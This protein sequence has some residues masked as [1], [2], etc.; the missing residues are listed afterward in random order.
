[1]KSFDAAIYIPGVI[2]FKN[3]ICVTLNFCVIVRFSKVTLI[4]VQII[5]NLRFYTR[6]EN[7]INNTAEALFLTGI[8][9]YFCTSWF[10]YDR[11]FKI[12]NYTFYLNLIMFIV[13]FTYFLRF[14]IPNFFLICDVVL[15]FFHIL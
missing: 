8:L 15:S 10:L 14:S 3:K 13:R 5:L 1:M 2:I 11:L 6:I 7:Y 12:M 4:Q 9:K